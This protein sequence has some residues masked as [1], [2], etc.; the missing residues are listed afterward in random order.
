[1]L[2]TLRS[3]PAATAGTRRSPLLL[4]QLP[5]RFPVNNNENQTKPNLQSP[6][7]PRR[8]ATTTGSKPWGQKHHT[9]LT[10][11]GLLASTGKPGRKQKPLS[12]TRLRGRQQEPGERHEASPRREKTN[13][14]ENFLRERRSVFLE[15]EIWVI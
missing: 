6:K 5:E 12:P 2:K 8:G 13:N 14:R 7:G 10:V 4:Q 11:G 15:R 3:G 1:M 9:T